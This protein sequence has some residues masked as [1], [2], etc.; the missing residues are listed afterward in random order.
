MARRVCSSELSQ[1]GPE[2]TINRSIKAEPPACRADLGKL[3]CTGCEPGAG[4]LQQ[5]SKH[6]QPYRCLPLLGD[7]L[8]LCVP[9]HLGTLV[10][11]LPLCSSP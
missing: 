2:K 9:H 4:K 10:W 11:K 7:L 5:L 8:L 6:F 3:E 1:V